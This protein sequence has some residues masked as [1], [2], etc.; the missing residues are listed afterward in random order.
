LALVQ[1]L[2]EESADGIQ[3][4]CC[5]LQSADASGKPMWHPH[6]HI[7]SGIDACGDCTLDTPERVV[8][9]HFVVADVNSGRRHAGM[10]TVK[11]RR[12]WLSR[13]GAP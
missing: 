5:R 6:P 3:C 8:Q 11:W 1:P 13:V 10:S 12:Q 9:Q 2:G 4:L 7:S